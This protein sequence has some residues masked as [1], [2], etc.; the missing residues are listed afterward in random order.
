MLRIQLLLTVKD[1]SHSG[2]QVYEG[3]ALFLL[4]AAAVTHRP[5]PERG[6]VST[7]NRSRPGASFR[8]SSVSYIRGQVRLTL[9]SKW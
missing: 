6:G 9:I 2:L 3:A 4:A 8:K 5:L 1:Q 7:G